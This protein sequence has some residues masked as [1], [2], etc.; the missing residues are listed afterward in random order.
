MSDI[1]I[2]LNA[3]QESPEAALVVECLEEGIKS[4]GSAVARVALPVQDRI[5]EA[6]KQAQQEQG[7][8]PLGAPPLV[9]VDT[10]D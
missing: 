8:S 3:T 5:I 7:N 2:K 1:T 6:V 9:E 4:R 10:E